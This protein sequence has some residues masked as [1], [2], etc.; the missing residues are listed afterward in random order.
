MLHPLPAAAASAAAATVA[1]A[2]RLLLHLHNLANNLAV[3]SV[4]ELLEGPALA[5]IELPLAMLP[6]LEGPALAK[7][8]Q[9]DT[10]LDVGSKPD[11]KRSRHLVNVRGQPYLA[12]SQFPQQPPPC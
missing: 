3:P 10:P 9:F 1:A 7:A 2:S 8:E 6:L 5:K 11:G 4:S 12:D